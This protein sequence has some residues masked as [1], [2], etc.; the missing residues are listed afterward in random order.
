MKRSVVR[1]PP[2]LAFALFA[3]WQAAGATQA[4]AGTP[5]VT[6]SPQQYS[7]GSYRTVSYFK[8]PARP[9]ATIR[10]GRVVIRNPG[11][12]ALR[13]RVDPVD[14]LT[15]DNLGSAYK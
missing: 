7:H 5:F 14:P 1:R 13:V 12:Q 10:V 6:I 2:V 15:S 8:V 3:I 11:A 9:G 4:A